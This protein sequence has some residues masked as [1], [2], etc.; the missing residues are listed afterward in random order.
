[1][2][3]YFNEGKQILQ[4]KRKKI[5]MQEKKRYEKKAKLTFI[6]VIGLIICFI[7]IFLSNL[8]GY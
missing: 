5:T 4:K 7:W 8:L 3:H 2:K 1:M 6:S